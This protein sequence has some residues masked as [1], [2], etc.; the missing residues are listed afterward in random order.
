MLTLSAI[1]LR[2]GG[3]V[4]RARIARW[5]LAALS[6]PSPAMLVMGAGTAAVT[7]GE[8][9]FRKSEEALAFEW[10]AGQA[11]SD[12]VLASFETGNALPAWAPVRVVIG[13]GPE[14]IGLEE[15]QQSV[16]RFYQGGTAGADREALLQRYAVRFI[17]EG[18]REAQLGGWDPGSS[19]AMRLV[20]DQDAYRIF[21][22]LP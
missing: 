4:S 17:F 21:E 12:V 16:R 7:P 3:R 22:V 20:Y 14:S 15:L 10:L 5:A 2:A 18:P 11:R 13:H 8:P 9:L 6:L 1:G 19:S